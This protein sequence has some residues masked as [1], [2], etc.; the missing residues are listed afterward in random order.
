MKIEYVW[1][2]L[3][4]EEKSQIGDICRR[5]TWDELAEKYSTGLLKPSGIA[6][7]FSDDSEATAFAE[8]LLIPR[9]QL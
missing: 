7:V 9:E 3:A 8:K 5:Y 4:P 1:M 6:A 2:V